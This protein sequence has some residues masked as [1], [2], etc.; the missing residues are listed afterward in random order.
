MNI[1][2]LDDLGNHAYL[3]YYTQMRGK[4]AQ[5]ASLVP[6]DN[7]SQDMKNAWICSAVTVATTALADPKH[8]DDILHSEVCPQQLDV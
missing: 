2:R 3:E 1:N 4:D 7:L 5:G 8:I 6:W